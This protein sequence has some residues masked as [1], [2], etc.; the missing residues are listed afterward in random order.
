MA[1][2]LEQ[3]IMREI[4]LGGHYSWFNGSDC[5]YIRN[6]AAKRLPGILQRYHNEGKEVAAPD[7]ELCDLLSDV[8][9]RGDDSRYT[10][11]NTWQAASCVIQAHLYL[12]HAKD[13]QQYQEIKENF[14]G[15][16]RGSHLPSVPRYREQ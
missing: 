15:G 3:Q 7:K 1:V 13:A 10:L 11:T 9:R 4:G 14:V 6:D 16:I 8:A 5:E 2:E 12:Y